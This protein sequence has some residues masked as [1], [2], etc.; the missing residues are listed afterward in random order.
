MEAI[1]NIP[2]VEICNLTDVEEKRPAAIITGN[3]AWRAVGSF[4]K[5]PVVVQAE[6]YT[7]NIE[8]LDTLAKGLPEQV[9]VVYGIGGGLACD[10][11]KYV[12][13]SKRTPRSHYPN[14]VKC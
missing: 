13:T 2:K 1:W 5:M 7:A 6:P 12:G 11:A 10:V 14:S 4:L 3:R 9:Q 8:F